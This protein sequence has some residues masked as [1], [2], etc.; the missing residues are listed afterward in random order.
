MIDKTDH[1]FMLTTARIQKF[2]DVKCL[3]DENKKENEGDSDDE[4]DSDQEE[5]RAEEILA[6]WE[7][8][9]GDEEK[10]QHFLDD[11]FFDVS[12]LD[13]DKMMAHILDC[14]SSLCAAQQYRVENKKLSKLDIKMQQA[15]NKVFKTAISLMSTGMTYDGEGPPKCCNALTKMIT[16]YDHDIGEEANIFPDDSK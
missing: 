14:Y 11:S 3:S 5:D 4:S 13:E 1:A 9:W 2:I 16:T 6:A 7:D 10:G 12:V 8:R 15:R